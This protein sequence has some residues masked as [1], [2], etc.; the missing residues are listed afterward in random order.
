MRRRG[1]IF[2][3]DAV[4]AL[5]LVMIFVASIAAVQSQTGNVYT[6]YSRLQDKYVAENTLTLLRTVPLTDLVPASVIANWTKEGILNTSLV[7]PTMSPLDIVTTY[8]ATGPLY[9]ETKLRHNAEI[10]LGYLLN[11]TLKGYDYELFIN[12]YTSPYL[13]KM[14]SMPENANDISPATLLLSGYAYN[15]TPRGYMARAYLTRFSFVRED[16]FGWFRVLAGPYDVDWNDNVLKLT[17]VI[18]LPG[19]AEIISAD[20]KFVRRMSEHQ[21]VE[22]NKGDSEHECIYGPV[23]STINENITSCM[24]PGKNVFTTVYTN[25]T[26]SYG[27]DGIGSASGTTVYVKYKSK[28]TSIEDPGIVRVYSVDSKYTGF[29]YLFEMFVPGNI[30]GI[31]MKFKVKGVSKVYLY[32]GLG[33]NLVLLT[34][35]QPDADGIVEFNDADIK[36]AVDSVLCGGSDCYAGFKANLSKMVFDFVIGFDAKY[37]S[38]TGRW[39]Y[40]G[41]RCDGIDCTLDTNVRERVLYGYPDSYI[42]IDYVPRTL[43]TPYSIPLAIYFPYGDPR[44]SYTGRGLQVNYYLPPKATPWYAD[45]WVGYSFAD[46]NTYQNLYENGGR[47]YRGPLG[48]YALRVAYTRLYD[49][50]MVPGDTNSFDIKMT[51]GNSKVR[52]GES[53]GMIKY[54]LQGYVGYGDIFPHLLQGYPEY[55]GYNLTYWYSFGGG[56]RQATILVGDPPYLSINVTKLKPYLYAVDDAVLR[57]FNE[58]NYRNDVNPKSWTETPFDGSPSNPIDLKPTASLRIETVSMGNIPGLFS[59]ITITLRVWREGG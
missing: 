51:D 1:F 37:N 43:I 53:R 27:Q 46:Y 28:S 4:L 45:W 13:Q 57:L 41:A 6:S 10:I 18:T 11:N 3:L 36:S 19:D 44:V 15:K 42:R 25:P 9:N 35:K 32:Y 12:N 52:D 38:R 5:V 7:S 31:N 54:F 59:P 20:A 8:W 55:N 17:R 50:M 47:F 30:T 34:S 48:R 16:L 39:E 58:L 23:A 40:S 2:T 56:S 49:W 22:I 26:D 24:R 33:G 29:F 14:N 21:T